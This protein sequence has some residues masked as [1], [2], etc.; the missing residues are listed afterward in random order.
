MFIQNYFWVIINI[1]LFF[2]LGSDVIQMKA[3]L[4]TVDI[5]KGFLSRNFWS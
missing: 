5:I 1:Y 4:F 3:N 2:V